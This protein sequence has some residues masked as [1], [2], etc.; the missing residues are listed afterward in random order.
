MM[1]FPG[2]QI[3]RKWTINQ[4]RGCL[5][6][7]SDRFDLTVE[8]IRRQYADE[9]SPLSATLDRYSDFFRLFREFRGYTDF[10]LLEDLVDADLT[11]RFFM[12]FDD[13]RGSAVPKD[14]DTY[15]EFRHRSM[16]FIQARNERIGLLRF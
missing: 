8:C 10:F 14:V 16:D 13:F 1:V 9:E 2:N 15:R 11:V 3:D 6:S 7:I 4:A 5:R 12:P